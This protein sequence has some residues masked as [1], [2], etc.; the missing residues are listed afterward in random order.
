MLRGIAKRSG[1][2]FFGLALGKVLTTIAFIWLAR[3]LMPEGL[4]QAIYFVTLLTI[5]TELGSFGLNQWYQTTIASAHRQTLF[6]T[7]ASARLISLGVSLLILTIFLLI[8]NP[9]TPTIE[10]ILFLCVIFEAA[11][12]ITKGYYLELNAPARVS[13][14]YSLKSGLL[15]LGMLMFYQ[16]I[17]VTTTV[18][19]LL[20]A[21]IAV[22]VVFFPFKALQLNR[23]SLKLGVKALKKSSGYAL[24]LFTS[25]SYSQGDSV[26]IRLTLGS[27]TL[28]LYGAAYRYLESINL[29]PRAVFDNVFPEAAKKEGVH[30]AGLIKMSVF[31]LACGLFFGITLYVLSDIITIGFL[32]MAFI[33]SAYL[34]KIFAAVLVM[35]FLN[36]PV[37]AVVQSSHLLKSFLPWGIANT[38][39][40]LVLNFTLLPKYGITAAAWTMLLTETT[41]FLINLAFA[42]KLYKTSSDL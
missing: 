22:F 21:T 11:L 20:V 30:R 15:L 32:G 2:Y 36:A 35:F 18:S 16:N 37:S 29:L 42:T 4:G 33:E 40:N 3:L 12:S 17:D 9:F 10:F 5:T 7:L 1:Q 27:S 39:L 28:G 26:I 23:L 25:L 38:I 6:T 19:I 34:V 41:G 14:Q 8:T 24:L 13:H 31:M